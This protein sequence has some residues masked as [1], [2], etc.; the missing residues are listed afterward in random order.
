M[1]DRI[2]QR[3]H[4]EAIS[5]R[6]EVDKIENKG[7]SS[8]YTKADKGLFIDES[9]ISQDA[10]RLYE[11]EQDVNKFTKLA[12]S[13]AEDTSADEIV[14]QKAFA[15]EISIDDDDAI[16]SILNN[17]NFLKDIEF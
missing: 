16:F 2:L 13:D 6:S 1:L 9:R 8:P 7:V 11:R 12:L 15:G 3:D 14:L 10:I 5:Q 17:D 4:N